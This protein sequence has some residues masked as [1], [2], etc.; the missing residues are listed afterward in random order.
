M[1]RSSSRGC[2][3]HSLSKT[4]LPQGARLHAAMQHCTCQCKISY[5]SD[6]LLRSDA[7]SR[8]Q[9]RALRET[10]YEVAARVAVYDA[11]HLARLQGLHP[12]LELL[13]HVSRA[14]DAQVA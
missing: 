8:E 5:R 4:W 3:R 2:Y 9:V 14:E 12:L 13:L 10:K 11:A 1:R 7:H 6:T